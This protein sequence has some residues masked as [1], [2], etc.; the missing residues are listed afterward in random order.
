MSVVKTNGHHWD[1]MLT[2]MKIELKKQN[3]AERKETI[4]HTCGELSTI[5][6]RVKSRPRTVRSF[7]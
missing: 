6:T 3:S 5:I 2:E 1:K 4:V 7:R